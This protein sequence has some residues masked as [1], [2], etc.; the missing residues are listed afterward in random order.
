[1]AKGQ[2]TL[3]KLIF[4][5]I[6]APGPASPGCTS[7]T[8]H[9]HTHTQSYRH[10]STT[11]IAAKNDMPCHEMG[12]RTCTAFFHNHNM[13]E[14]EESVFRNHYTLCAEDNRMPSLPA[15]IRSPFLQSDPHNWYNNSCI[16]NCFV[17]RQACRATITQCSGL[18]W[19]GISKK[20]SSYRT[21]R[22]WEAVGQHTSFFWAPLF[23]SN[24]V[25]LYGHRDNCDHPPFGD[26]VFPVT[27]RIYIT[28][29]THDTPFLRREKKTNCCSHPQF[30]LKQPFGHSIQQQPLVL[31]P[32]RSGC[33]SY[34]KN[35][36]RQQHIATESGE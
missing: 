9:T 13:F 29:N 30:L 16:D 21:Q 4:N 24:I 31:I 11:I 10:E 1:M 8:N 34:K 27:R 3:Q 7:T 33:I 18:V 6:I 15:S 12:T 20:P 22:K 28:I 5:I 19:N 32:F 36:P 17:W 35:S 25:V 23:S 2:H 26:W 14:K